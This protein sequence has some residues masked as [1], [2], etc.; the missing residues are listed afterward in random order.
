MSEQRTASVNRETKETKIDLNLDLDGSGR[1]EIVT[2]I[3]FFDHMLEA[4]AR[5][6]LLDLRIE[7]SGDLEVDE[8]HTVEDVG[9]SLGQ[10]IVEALGNKK[11]IARFGSAYAPLDEALARTVIDLSGRP[12]LT[13]NA[14]ILEPSPENFSSSV[15]PEFFRAVTSTGRFTCHIDL[16]SG[17]N[18]HHQV[19]AIFKSFALALRSALAVDPRVEGIPSTKGKL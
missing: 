13:F 18:F 19:E 5:H 11:G 4:L 10:A 2:G 3:G 9:L 12:H 15:I 1:G 16:M 7:C 6:G 8:H 17:D 14:E